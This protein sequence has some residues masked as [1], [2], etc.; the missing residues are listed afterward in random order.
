MMESEY[1]LHTALALWSV[2][3]GAVLCA[4]YDV[5][6]AF[7]LRKRQNAVLLFTFDFLYCM[8]AAVFMLLLF[9]NLS[10]GKARA[11]AFL[12]A[13]C[14]FL[15]WRFT[16]SRVFTALVIRISLFCERILNLIK[17]RL[18]LAMIWLWRRIY[19]KIYCRRLITTA[20]N[21]K[22]VKRKEFRNDKETDPS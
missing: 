2:A 9:F 20:K 6:R 14:G 15:I 10:Y 7:R 21:G 17:M 16:V 11:Y 22:L 3:V 18:C 8:I 13:L 4:V 19:T 12:F 1:F 5:F